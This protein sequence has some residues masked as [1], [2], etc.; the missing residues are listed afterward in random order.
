MGRTF[1][2]P[3]RATVPEITAVAPRAGYEAPLATAC[4]AFRMLARGGDSPD[5]TH[6][7]SP[8]AGQSA[9]NASSKSRVAASNA[10]PRRRALGP[11]AAP[12]RFDIVRKLGVGS[13]LEL[14]DLALT[15]D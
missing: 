15:R 2:Q 12:K 14:N 13:R 4:D 7:Q 3:N 6:A 1:S 8:R 10:P 9:L 11:L 5:A